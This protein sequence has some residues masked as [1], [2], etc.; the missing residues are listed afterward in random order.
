MAPTANLRIFLHKSIEG[1]LTWTAFPG[2]WV[3]L[4]PLET[5]LHKTK[6]KVL[7]S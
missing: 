3:L 1:S 7:E 4:D 6:D 2:G 5:C